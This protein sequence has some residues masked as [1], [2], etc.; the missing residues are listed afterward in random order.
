MTLARL[1]LAVSRVRVWRDNQFHYSAEN[2]LLMKDNA[3]AGPRTLDLMVKSH[4]LFQ[5]ELQTQN[6]YYVELAENNRFF[7]R[8]SPLYADM[9]SNT[10]F[11]LQ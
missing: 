11:F 6:T 8:A 7:S 5:S 1:E 10:M 9:V 2:Y 3:P 4:L